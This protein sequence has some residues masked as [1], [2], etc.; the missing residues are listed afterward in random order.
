MFK[1]SLIYLLFSILVVIFARF[2]FMLIIYINILLAFVS[3]H[4]TPI[5]R[6]V[7]LGMVFQ[8]TILLVC[9]PPLLAAIPTLIYRLARGK[10]M[11][12]FAELTWGLWLVILLSNVLLKASP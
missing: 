1:Q 7:G 9:I 2:A 8:R 11:P 10:I 4:L 3:V 6:Q 12:Y 5:V